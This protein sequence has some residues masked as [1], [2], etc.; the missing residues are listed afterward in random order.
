MNIVFGMFLRILLNLNWWITPWIMMIKSMHLRQITWQLLRT[1]R[2]LDIDIEVGHVI[3]D[4]SL[5]VLIALNTLKW[6]YLLELMVVHDW[7][8]HKS[9]FPMRT[10]HWGC[11]KLSGFEFQELK[12]QIEHLTLFSYRKSQYTIMKGKLCNENLLKVCEKKREFW[13]TRYKILLTIF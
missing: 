5:P 12:L 2:I 9:P 4:F 13:T 10:Y 6:S 8:L 11:C 3:W 1:K 7:I